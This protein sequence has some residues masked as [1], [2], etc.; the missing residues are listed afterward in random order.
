MKNFKIKV[1]TPIDE[2][3]FEL[4][5]KLCFANIVKF[6]NAVYYNNVRFYVKRV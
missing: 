3:E 2:V 6:Y 1:I 5:T 4:K